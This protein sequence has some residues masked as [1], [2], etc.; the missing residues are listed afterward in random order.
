MILFN[1]VLFEAKKFPI[2]ELVIEK[3]WIFDRK[4]FTNK[5]TLK[6]EGDQD[7]MHLFLLKNAMPFP[8]DLEITYMPYSRMDRASNKYSFTLKHVCKFINDLNFNSVYLIEPHSDVAPALLNR[9]RTAN[10]L[11]EILGKTDFN[12]EKD[13]LLYPDSGAYK[14]YSSLINSQN[15]LIGVKKRNFETGRISGLEV[16]AINKS[17]H[18]KRVFIIDDLCSKGTTFSIAAKKISSLGVSNIFLVVAHCEETI[19]KGDIL[20]NESY[21]EKV[22]TSDTIPRKNNHEKIKVFAV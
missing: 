15:E 19:F 17:P 9:C 12:A 10:I 5:I 18:G 21:I 13:F 20:T 4:D 3:S 7:L 8:V 22:Y 2:G 1:N 14:K 16:M 6:Y 11:P